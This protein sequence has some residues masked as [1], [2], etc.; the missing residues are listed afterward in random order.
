MMLESMYYFHRTCEK[1]RCSA[2]SLNAG[3]SSRRSSTAATQR[4]LRLSGPRARQRAGSLLARRL[5]WWRRSWRSGRACCRSLS[6]STRSCRPSRTRCRRPGWRTWTRT[7]TLTGTASRPSNASSPRQPRAAVKLSAASRT[8]VGR[9]V[10]RS[11]QRRTAPPIKRPWTKRRG[12]NSYLI[13]QNTQ[14]HKKI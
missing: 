8:F 10:L 9:S 13:V 2:L 12:N 1:L 14:N 11:R 7:V 3:G 4:P 6:S 5:S